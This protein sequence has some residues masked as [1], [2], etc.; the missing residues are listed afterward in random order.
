MPEKRTWNDNLNNVYRDVLFA[1]TELKECMAIPE[2]EH[3]NIAAFRDRYFV[4][5]PIPDEIVT[6]EKVRVAWYTEEGTM[7][8]DPHVRKKYLRFD[9]YC[10]QDELY[11]YGIDRICPRTQKIA[12][13]IKELLV[14]TTYVCHLKFDYEDEYDLSTKMVGYRRYC[15]LFSYK[16]T[17]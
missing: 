15:I 9:I 4:R 6:D 8:G 13:R 11:T 17:W 5:S 2:S 7:F 12:E 10:H 14:G 3:D 16:V 1:D